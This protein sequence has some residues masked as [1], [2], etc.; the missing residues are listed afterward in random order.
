M[1]T[2]SFMSH[3]ITHLLPNTFYVPAKPNFSSSKKVTP[4]NSHHV[5]SSMLLPFRFRGGKN[6]LES[7]V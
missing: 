5:F 1:S 4:G 3:S 6:R 2:M 7:I